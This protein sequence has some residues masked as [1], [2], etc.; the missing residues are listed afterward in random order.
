MMRSLFIAFSI[1]GLSFSSHAFALKV[2]VVDM[3]R[4]ILTVEEGKAARET[5]QQEIRAK[6][7]ELRKQKEE[8]D[9]LNEEWKTQAA[10]LSE[11]ARMRKQT[12]FQE[13]FMKLRNEE[14]QFQ[15]TIKQKEAEATQKIALRVTETVN[16]LAKEKALDLVFETNSSGLMYAKDPTNLTDE[17]IK[18]YD[19]TQV[20]GKKISK[21]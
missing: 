19:K 2:G 17:V 10:L 13:K 8:L 11:D 15:Q 16:E 3:Q 9:K 12:E 20:P 21:K 14:I 4:I 5:L 18:L 6:E 7:N 1:L